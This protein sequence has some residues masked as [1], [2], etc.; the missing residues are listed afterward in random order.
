[1]RDIDRHFLKIFKDLKIIV[2]EHGS[3]DEKTNYVCYIG[4]NL[5][6]IQ[7]VIGMVKEYQDDIVNMLIRENK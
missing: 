3:T 2:D 6:R 4:K 5:I 7:D 1:M